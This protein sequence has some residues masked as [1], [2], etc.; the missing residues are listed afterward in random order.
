MQS[1]ILTIPAELTAR[2]FE[3]MR[4]DVLRTDYRIRPSITTPPLV[5]IR[6]CKDW[7]A[8]ALGTG[9]LWSCIDLH[10]EDPSMETRDKLHRVLATWSERARG[11]PLSWTLQ[12]FVT[13]PPM[14]PVVVSQLHRL[15][16]T[17][18]MPN[19]L[20]LGAIAT[21]FPQLRDLACH[22]LDVEDMPATI[23]PILE[24]GPKLEAISLSFSA[25]AN[26]TGA[27]TPRLT[28]FKV[29]EIT[30][31]ALRA[32]FQNCPMLAHLHITN[33]LRETPSPLATPM[34][35]PN[36]QT[37]VIPWD[38]TVTVADETVMQLAHFSFP[39]LK[40][41]RLP[42]T[43]HLHVVSELFRRSA[44]A[45]DT[46]SVN[47]SSVGDVLELQTMYSRMPSITTLEIRRWEDG[48]NPTVTPLPEA[49]FDLSVP[50]VLPRLRNLTIH[51][52]GSSND[53]PYNVPY[54]GVI[55]LLDARSAPNSAFHSFHLDVEPTSSY[56]QESYTPPANFLSQIETLAQQTEIH[57][58][59]GEDRWLGGIKVE[60]PDD[61]EW[62]E[63]WLN[64]YWYWIP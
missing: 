6:V 43:P 40:C 47:I 55:L 37:V 45:I 31:S 3:D 15:E 53:S 12:G 2:I 30:V 33:I 38:T 25:P 11:H 64:P 42:Y 34:T 21:G 44:C 24:S 20:L 14:F 62:R 17:L 7:R 22:V 60:A 9:S 48:E 63:K 26:F 41:L 54:T 56:F 1:P 29:K 61:L 5:L 27:T 13:L 16:L 51:T 57:I 19:P 35:A 10:I 36:L 52:G 18:L 4:L 39:S 8:I 50:G 49:V 23:A 32:L 46:L 28:I 59:N 58:I